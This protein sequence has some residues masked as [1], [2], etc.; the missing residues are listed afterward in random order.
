MIETIFNIIL[1]KDV[2]VYRL[3]GMHRIVFTARIRLRRKTPENCYI[4][5]N[6][7][8]SCGTCSLLNR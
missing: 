7:F 1:N 8:V 6:L 5:V 2:R 4:F 3:L